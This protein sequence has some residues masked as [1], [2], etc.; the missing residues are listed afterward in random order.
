MK[1]S[2]SYFILLSL[3]CLLTFSTDRYDKLE[4]L[5]PRAEAAAAAQY[6][7]NDT[8]LIYWYVCGTDLE[9]KY[10]AASADL[11]EL[12]QVKLPPN[13]KVLI[14]T[15]GAKAWQA[16]NIPANAVARWL[17]DSNGVQLLQELPDADMGAPGTLTDFLR[18][19]KE[20]FAAD[21]RVFIFWDH[22]GGSAVG[23]AY[24]ERTAHILSLNDIQRSFA[25]VE[26]PDSDRPP[27]ELIGFDACL[28]STID[29]AQSLYGLARYMVASEEVEPA[30]GWN[31]TGWGNALAQNPGMNGAALG[32]VI[33]DSYLDD[34]KKYGTADAAT[35]S[36]VD[37]S[38]VPQLQHAYEA[39]G[40]EAL[41]SAYKDPQRF[42][43]AFARK[44][45]ATENYGGNTREQGYTNMADLGSLV[46]NAQPL[47]PQSAGSLLAEL[48]S[49]VI[50]KVSGPYRQNSTGLSCYYSFNGNLEHL[51]AYSKVDAAAPSFKYLYT[52][53]LTGQMPPEA[54]K[55]LAVSGQEA[56]QPKP[57][58]PLTFN[59][60]S[61]ED[62]KVD[63]DHE[64]NA[65]VILTPTMMDGLSSVHCQFFYYGQTEN[66]L[67][68]LGSDANINADWEKG[69]FKDNFQGKWPMLDG[70]PVYVEITQEEDD[71]NLY[72][73]PVLLNGQE[74]NLQIVYNF[75]EAKYHILGA[76]R[77]LDE[78]GVADR[79]LIKLK[80]GDRITTLHYTIPVNGSEED[81]KQVEVDTFTLAGPPKFE[82]EAVGDGKYGYFFEFV[83]PQNNSALSKMVLFTVK[84]GQIYTEVEATADK[85]LPT[86]P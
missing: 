53:L 82:D 47:L 45:A 13:V 51:R 49:S 56:A 29:T 64:G 67:L 14:E 12:T 68:Y 22:G 80:K 19:G 59:V 81:C 33:C 78:S 77:G 63:I 30:N 70:H 71:Y 38:R 85:K 84:D 4:N 50:Y 23:V 40:A 20:N 32:S 73:V 41:Q 5:F 72:S 42:F 65:F 46:R 24:D 62:T 86:K 54:K 75:S 79:N 69:V 60:Q 1:K 3:F 25:Y 16:E 55:Y 52:Y 15:G 83:D 39:V 34:C 2:C 26:T 44:A 6:G 11:S 61:L 76:R 36:V 10:G 57:A 21:H 7:Q 37:L 9:S 35:L 48:N 66:L 17:Y 31:Y 27:F 58:A 28:M 8:W 74:C 43:S 18:Y